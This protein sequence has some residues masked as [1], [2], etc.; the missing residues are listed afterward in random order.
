MEDLKFYMGLEKLI[1]QNIPF[2]DKVLNEEEKQ[3][4]DELFKRADSLIDDL[5]IKQ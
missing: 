2:I 4:V 3:I 1:T 5:E